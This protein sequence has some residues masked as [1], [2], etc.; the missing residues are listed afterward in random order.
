VSTSLSLDILK[1][2]LPLLQEFDGVD[3]YNLIFSIAN[4]L[5]GE[6][7]NKSFFCENGGA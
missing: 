6:K 4:I 2:L 7:Q 5:K 1:N 3:Q